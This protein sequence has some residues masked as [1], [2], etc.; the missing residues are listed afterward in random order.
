MLDGQTIKDLEIFEST[1]TGRSLFDLCNFTRSNKGAKALK[2]RMRRPWAVAA[3]I[4]AV[5]DTLSFMLERQQVFDGLPGFI[6]TDLVESYLHGTLPLTTSESLLEFYLEAIDLRFGD[7]PRYSRIRHGVQSTCRL[8][9][10]LRQIV[11]AP[12]LESPPGELGPIIAELIRNF[13]P[14]GLQAVT[15]RSLPSDVHLT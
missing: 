4:R 9:R 13:R 12:G 2:A 5:Q 15:K 14:V 3:R 7:T 6:T 1:A 8:V 10:A 11:Q